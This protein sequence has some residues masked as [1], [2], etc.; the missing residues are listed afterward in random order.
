MQRRVRRL[1][2]QLAELFDGEAGVTHEAAHGECVDWIVARDG[3]D[4]LAIRHHDVLALTCDPE[5]RLFEGAHCIKVIDAWN[6]G[7][8]LHR[9]FDFANFFA[10]QLL[11]HHSEIFP[12]GITDVIQSLLLGGSLRPTSG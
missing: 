12:N 9:N 4:S 11:V 8:A 10:L 5:P 1:L 6:L 3:E 7:Q 2:E